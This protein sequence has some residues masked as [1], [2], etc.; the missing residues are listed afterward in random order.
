MLIARVADAMAACGVSIAVLFQGSDHDGSGLLSPEGLGELFGLAGVQ[1][2]PS[3]VAELFSAIDT[4]RDGSVS[5][6]ELRAALTQSK[7]IGVTTSRVLR[8]VGGSSS[9]LDH[10]GLGAS[11]LGRG[12]SWNAENESSE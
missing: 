3:E 4:D 1:L 6:D 11:M 8:G 7:G 5:L 10:G 12:Q 2:A 9:P